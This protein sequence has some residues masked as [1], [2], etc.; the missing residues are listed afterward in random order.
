M[1]VTISRMPTLGKVFTEGVAALRGLAR[2]RTW[3]VR[4]HRGV[5]LTGPGRYD[6]RAGSIIRPGARIW[7]GPDGTLTLHAGAQIGGRCIINVK[8]GLAVGT[9]S[10][11]SWDCQVLDTDFHQIVRDDGSRSAMTRPIVIGERVLVATGAII[12]KGVRLG[13]DSVVGAGS[14]VSAGDYPP[15]VVLVG[16]PAQVRSKIEGWIP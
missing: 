16:N 14:V 8:E 15:K 6:L 11:I 4:I 7:V 2:T 12:L 5:K 9:G 3:G 13:D 10:Q 1:T